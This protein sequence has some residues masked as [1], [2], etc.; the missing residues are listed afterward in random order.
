LLAQ[1][2]WYARLYR[3]QTVDFEISESPS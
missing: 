3:R 2:G 1:G